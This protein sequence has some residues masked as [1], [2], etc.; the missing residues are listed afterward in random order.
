M[1]KL[2][3]IVGSVILNVFF[4][5]VFLEYNKLIWGE[6]RGYYYFTLLVGLTVGI[7][8]LAIAVHFLG[9]LFKVASKTPPKFEHNASEQGESNQEQG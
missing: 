3:I 9:K 5:Y 2:V 8:G 6:E 1:R 7:F 4:W